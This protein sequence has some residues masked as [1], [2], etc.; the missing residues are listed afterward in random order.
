[1]VELILK[2][3]S[4]NSERGMTLNCQQNNFEFLKMLYLN[5]TS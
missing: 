5:Q 1:M 3:F 2:T 4:W